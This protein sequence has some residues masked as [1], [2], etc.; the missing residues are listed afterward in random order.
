M[1]SQGLEKREAE[2][3]WLESTGLPDKET[4]GMGERTLG[5]KT[6]TVFWRQR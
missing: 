1:G 3:A 4:Q 5:K 6:L 2:V